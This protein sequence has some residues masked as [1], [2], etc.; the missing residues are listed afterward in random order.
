MWSSVSL[1]QRCSSSSVFLIVYRR[2][3]RYLLNLVGVIG[4]RLFGFRY[5]I[6][7]ERIL[8]DVGQ[9]EENLPPATLEL[10]RSISSC[11]NN[12]TKLTLSGRILLRVC[13][14]SGTRKWILTQKTGILLRYPS[15]EG[16]YR[17]L[18]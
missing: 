13:R 10:L 6:S 15:D 12:D 18:G 7:L 14:L 16:T 9:E 5:D 17:K 3:R 2:F 11:W 4:Y 1:S 8:K